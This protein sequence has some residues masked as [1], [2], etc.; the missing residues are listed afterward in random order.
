MS[1]IG[2][3]VVSDASGNIANV[4][5]NAL[6]V[7]ANVIFPDTVE[8]TQ[9][10][11]PW[12]VS[13]AALPLP[14]GA[15]TSSLQTTGNTN[16]VN[17]LNALMSTLS[18]AIANASLAVTQSGGWNVGITGTVPL[19]TG[20]STAALQPAINGDGGAL[21]HITNFPA[22]QPVSAVAL[23]LPAG[24]STAALQTSG[25]SSLTIIAA[26]TPALGQAL[27][28]ASSPVVLPAA[29]ITSLIAPN[30]NIAQYG[31]TATS[32]GQKTAVASI[33]VT[34]ASDNGITQAAVS[35]GTTSAPAAIIVVSG[36]T[37]DGT[38]V[39]SAI[40]LIAGGLAL[41]VA[42]LGLART[43]SSGTV[44]TS[45]TQALAA[46]AARRILELQNVSTTQTLG[47]TTDGTTAAIGSAGT[48]TLLPG[49]GYNPSVPPT[50]AIEVIGSSASTPFTL[51][52]A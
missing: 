5:D 12:A 41:S 10:T 21:A 29:Q 20:A 9:G 46:N 16:L 39:Y 11:D 40:P 25:N 47:F 49:Q 42:P 2:K 33:P 3:A 14:A 48:F 27:A 8:V 50:G 18:V 37:S 51:K 28:A 4:T 34:L 30:A 43:D 1:F 19:P 7:N 6:D 15:A 38:P 32:L 24:A 45:S 22:T 36:K 31:G 26:G 23:P 13:A 52:S 35:P 17:I 44:G